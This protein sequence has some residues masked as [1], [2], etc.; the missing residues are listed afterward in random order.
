LWN[1]QQSANARDQAD[2]KYAYNATRETRHRPAA[3]AG[4]S[5][6]PRLLTLPGQNKPMK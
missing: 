1:E 5:A 4:F 2:A 3:L 6:G